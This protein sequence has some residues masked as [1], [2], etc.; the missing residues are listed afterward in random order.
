MHEEFNGMVVKV[1]FT[2]P[3]CGTSQTHQIHTRS[4]HKSPIVVCCDVTDVPGCGRYLAIGFSL[5][6]IVNVFIMR[7]EE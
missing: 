1:P 5:R 7:E 3:Y 2:C 4:Q 6:P